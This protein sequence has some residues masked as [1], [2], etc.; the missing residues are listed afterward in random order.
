MDSTPPINANTQ[1][2]VSILAFAGAKDLLRKSFE[3][4][5]SND[6]N[7]SEIRLTIP[8]YWSQAY[9]LR[10]FLCRNKWPQLERIEQ[11]IAI[12]LNLKYLPLDESVEINSGDT[13]ALIPPISGG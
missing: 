11:N 5:E 3:V 1:V 8:S 7:N 12:A 10:R 9:D 13:L 6:C 2:E 4:N